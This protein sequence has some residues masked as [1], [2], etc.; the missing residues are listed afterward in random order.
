MVFPADFLWGVSTSGF[1]SEMG[2]PK[3]LNVDRDSDWYLWTHDVTNIQRGIVSGD[4]PENGVSSWD[5]CEKDHRIALSMGLNAY[6]IGI[7]WSRVFPE[8]TVTIDTP[9]EKSGDLFARVEVSN[10][11]L[12]RLDRVA[13]KSAIIHYRKVIKDLREKSFKVFVCLNHFTLPLWVHNPIAAR[14]NIFEKGQGGWVEQNTVVEFTKY[15]AYLAWKLGDL[16]D[17]WATFN[18][19]MVISELGYAN[20]RSG[21]PPGLNH[22]E[23]FKQVVLNLIAA[24]TRAYDAIKSVDKLRADENSL[25]PANVGLIHNVIPSMPFNAKADR[26]VKKAELYDQIHNHFVVQAICE[27]SLKNLGS[28]EERGEICKE[29][30]NRLDWLGVNYYTRSVFKGQSAL[31]RFAHRGSIVPDAADQYGFLC[32]A[33]GVSADGY[34]TSDFG[35]EIY[36]EGLMIALKAMQR[37]KRPLYVMENGVADRNDKIRSK[38]IVDHIEQLDCA[39]NREN[40][41]VKGYFHWSLTDNYEWAK[42]FSMKFG[43]CEVDPY[44]K[45]RTQ[46]K[47]AK[48]YADLIAKHSLL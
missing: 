45:K 4:F 24:H 31:S 27:G 28:P 37:Y 47:S 33:N 32:R 17:E 42:G 5:F 30:K 19:P 15:A 23:L 14:D 20:S 25:L 11:L 12:E 16:V 29:L 38:F 48:V 13:N 2:N 8:S 43:L 40:I 7:E 21:F 9:F 44:S 6:R 39:L 10:S 22:D 34:P 41:D 18:E 26:D 1:Q 46:K 3:G 35:W 36:P